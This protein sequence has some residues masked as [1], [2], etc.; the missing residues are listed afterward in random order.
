MIGYK[1]LCRWRSGGNDGRKYHSGVWGS[2]KRGR[3]T[4][5]NGRDPQVEY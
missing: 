1:G 4:E 2:G 3:G 5:S